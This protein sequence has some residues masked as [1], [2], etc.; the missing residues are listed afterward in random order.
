MP[1]QPITAAFAVDA[2]TGVALPHPVASILPATSDDGIDA[3]RRWQ[4]HVDAGRIGNIVRD[5]PD[6]LATEAR[7]REM[8]RILGVRRGGIW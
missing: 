2:V 7:C 8:E 4:A 5:S 1:S 6:R 3:L